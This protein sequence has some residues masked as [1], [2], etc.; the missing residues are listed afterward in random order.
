MMYSKD[1]L[2][3]FNCPNPKCNAKHIVFATNKNAKNNAELILLDD[4]QGNMCAD[5]IVICPKCKSKVA[6]WDHRIVVA[7]VIDNI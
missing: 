2:P 7:P 5:F 4:V 3:N 6:V 1:K